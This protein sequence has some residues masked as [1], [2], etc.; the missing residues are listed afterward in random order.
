M[1]A[2]VPW[3]DLPYMKQRMAQVDPPKEASM[4]ER[5]NGRSQLLFSNKMT[6]YFIEWMTP[7]CLLKKTYYYPCKK[8]DISNRSS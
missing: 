5:I 1:A 8:N 3:N 4:F 2:T 7:S 6:P